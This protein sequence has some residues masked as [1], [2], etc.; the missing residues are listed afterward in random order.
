MMISIVL[1]GPIILPI[2]T[3][4]RVPIH[5]RLF[6]VSLTSVYQQCLPVSASTL[7]IKYLGH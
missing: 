7:V 3:K 6:M 2:I 1:K 5:T 4:R